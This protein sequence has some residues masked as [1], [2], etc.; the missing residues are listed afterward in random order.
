MLGSI[1][2]YCLFIALV[3]A[4]TWGVYQLMETPGAIVV[5][6]ANYEYTLTP[7]AFVVLAAIGFA[8]LLILFKVAGLLL[9]LYRFICGDET[10]ISRFFNRSRERRGFDSL[11]QALTALAEGDGAKAKTKAE[12]A[13]R[14]LERPDVTQLVTAQAAEMS[15][16]LIKARK[17]YKALAEEKR[18]S[19]A[20]V[21]GLLELANNDGDEERA[22][23][24]ANQAYQLR[25]KN[26]WVLDN[27]YNLQSRSFD[28]KGARKTLAEQRRAG[29]LPKPEANRRDAMLALAQSEDA[30]ELGHHESAKRL[31]IDAAKLDPLNADAVSKAVRYLVAAGSKRAANRLITK[32]WG[33]TP[34]PQLAAAYAA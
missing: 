13:E 2:R 26:A 4:A 25:P 24:L 19:Y 27:L 8:A 29:L 10:A 9:A 22:L 30:E 3:A 18:S 16:D 1:L 6:F 32:A 14:L 11:S 5:S 12:K 17:Y 7:L 28:W 33:F 20:G 31:A 15:G 23:K 34:G 21:K